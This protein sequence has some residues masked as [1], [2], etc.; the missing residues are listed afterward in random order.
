MYVCECVLGCMAMSGC[1]C[2][3]LCVCMY[4]G[5]RGSVHKKIPICSTKSKP[6]CKIKRGD[7]GSVLSNLLM[8]MSKIAVFANSNQQI[9]FVPPNFICL[10]TGFYFFAVAQIF[11]KTFCSGVAREPVFVHPC[12]ELH[13]ENACMVL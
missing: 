9:Q 5:Y 11:L 2:L 4:A 3:C 12:I 10:I 6:V 8:K 7:V 1:V 13:P